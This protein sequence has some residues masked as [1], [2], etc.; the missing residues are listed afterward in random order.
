M[1]SKHG[2]E[3]VFFCVFSVALQNCFCYLHSFGKEK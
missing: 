3:C 2:D 1:K